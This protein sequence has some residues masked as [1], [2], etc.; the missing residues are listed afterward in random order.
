MNK[1]S[2]ES[3]NILIRFFSNPI[4]GITGSVASIIGVVLG[5]YFFVASKHERLLTYFVHPVKSIVATPE[6]ASKLSI[7]LED[8]KIQSDITA[9]Q[10]AFWNAGNEAIRSE[11]VLKPLI[12]RAEGNTQIIEARLRKKSREIVNLNID[13]DR[14]DK[15]ILTITWNILE[16]GDGGI[17]QLIYLGTP[18]TQITAEAIIEG[19]DHIQQE[20][21]RGKILTPGEQYASHSESFY[22][23]IFIFLGL[24]VFMG[25]VYTVKVFHRRRKGK[26][27][28]QK[29]DLMLAANGVMIVFMVILLFYK[30]RPIGPPFGF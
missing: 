20:E 22:I 5:I 12:I 19:Q 14:L 2:P 3:R 8:K 23:F 15:G 29:H 21:F 25:L 7:Y 30:S 1:S 6:T 9:A 13:R 24:F 18:N 17:I 4:V 16:K 26:K 10:I 27:M 28:F 11:H